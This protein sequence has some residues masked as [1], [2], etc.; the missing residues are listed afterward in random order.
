MFFILNFLK[1]M[2][3]VLLHYVLL[4]I[5]N[6]RRMRRE[7]YCICYSITHFTSGYSRPKRTHIFSG[8]CQKICRVF[9]ETALVM[10]SFNDPSAVLST[11]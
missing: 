3:V 8:G 7:G 10:A 4:H 9:S 2:N 6:P 5:I 1:C 11:K